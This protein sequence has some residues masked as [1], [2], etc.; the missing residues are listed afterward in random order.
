MKSITFTKLPN[1]R[2]SIPL[3]ARTLTLVALVL[4]PATT[5]VADVYPDDPA[6]LWPGGVVPFVYN[7]DVTDGQKCC[8]VAA[9]NIWAA[10]ASISF[11]PR[12]NE[13]DYLEIRQGG[14]GPNYPGPLGYSAGSGVHYLN[15][16]TW[17]DGV[18]PCGSQSVAA[19]F[20]LAHEFGHVLGFSHTQQRQDRD[21]YMVVNTCLIDPAFAGNYNVDGSSLAW[22]RNEMDVESIM[23]YPVCIYSV[24]KTSDCPS[25]PNNCPSVS[26]GTACSSDYDSCATMTFLP[27]YDTIWNSLRSCPSPQ[28]AGD[29]CVG[30]RNHLSP[31]DKWLIKFLYPPSNWRFVEKGYNDASPD[32][33]FHHPYEEIIE[34]VEALPAAGG[35]VVVQPGTY[36]DVTI[37]NKKS[38]II[39]P[40]GAVMR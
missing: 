25:P 34:G 4:S 35:T 18:N 29:I 30:H 19:D 15:V 14:T 3:V 28:S 12:T 39:A 1:S 37:L 27:P 2:N 24:C 13:S 6:R 16:N 17:C 11:V 21:A 5:L 20:G 33:T 40:L 22:P 36:T 7:A 9:M 23:A 10:E 38:I 8:I 26:C 31:R 32:G